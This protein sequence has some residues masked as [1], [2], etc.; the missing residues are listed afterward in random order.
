MSKLH[1]DKQ[2]YKDHTTIGLYSIP[3]ITKIYLPFLG[4]P[5]AP[6]VG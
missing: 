2:L 6:L 5:A 4:S 1:Y 3:S